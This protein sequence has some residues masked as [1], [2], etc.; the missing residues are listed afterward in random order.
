MTTEFMFKNAE[1][2]KEIGYVNS[3]D[4]QKDSQIVNFFHNIQPSNELK[5]MFLNKQLT[6]DPA[7]TLSL[8]IK[9]LRLNTR[10]TS[11]I[12]PSF[13]NHILEMS[14]KYTLIMPPFN[15]I[16]QDIVDILYTGKHVN[17]RKYSYTL[18]KE[19]VLSTFNHKNYTI[20]L[21]IKIPNHNSIMRIN[22]LTQIIEILGLEDTVYLI[23]L[24]INAGFY[25]GSTR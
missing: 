23:L 18:D 15:F 13:I 8:I 10:S 20:E 3:L 25:C 17:L 14:K 1:F 4:G 21:D 7:Y 6:K 24:L 11:Q 12:C 19:F 22:E 16:F 2:Q 9:F 5:R